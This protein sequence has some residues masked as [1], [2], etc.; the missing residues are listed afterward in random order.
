M[1][2][3]IINI[4][5]Q[6]NDGEGD[7][8]RTAFGKIN[9]NFTQL[10]NTGYFTSNAYSTGNVAG[11]VIFESP[12]ETF[13]QGVFQIN[14]N[15][16]SNTD[17]ENITLTVSVINDGSGLKWNGHNT[18]FNG[19]VLTGYNMDIFESNVRILVNPLIDTEIFHFISAQI[20][21]TGVPVPGLNLIT[22]GSVDPV[23]LDTEVG[24]EIQTENQITV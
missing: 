21:W 11:Q 16:T 18:L 24:F 14:S 12:V 22:D 1:T 6:P 8:L 5:A 23:L 20:T 13:T 2:Q 9:N 7:P 3:Q 4:G 19:N 15:D 10:F 17:T